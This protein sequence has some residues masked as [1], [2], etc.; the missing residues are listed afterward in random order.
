MERQ[1]SANNML[2]NS[3]LL[4]SEKVVGDAL[5]PCAKSGAGGVH[6]DVSNQIAQALVSSSTKAVAV[7]FG[8]TKM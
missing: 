8:D 4:T 3:M 5:A 6:T 7:I 2:I 1:G